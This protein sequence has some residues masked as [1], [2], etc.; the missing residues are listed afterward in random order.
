MRNL[1][2]IQTRN[3][4]NLNRGYGYPVLLSGRHKGSEYD[5]V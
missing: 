1:N 3:Q 2:N 4:Q 5:G